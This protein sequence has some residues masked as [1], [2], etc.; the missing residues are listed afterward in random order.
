MKR[1]IFGI[2]VT[3]IVGFQVWSSFSFNKGAYD[4]TASAI[5]QM[6]LTL[7]ALI[8][9]C[10]MLFKKNISSKYFAYMLTV[11]GTK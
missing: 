1:L 11:V 4:V 2:G 6:M 7:P 8:P 9:A 5:K 10:M 3:L